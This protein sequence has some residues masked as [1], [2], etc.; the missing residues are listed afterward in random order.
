MSQGN[1][2]S[3][4]SSSLRPCKKQR[5][6]GLNLAQPTITTELKQELLKY[7]NKR[8]F[9]GDSYDELLD[10]Y[11]KYGYPGDDFYNRLKELSNLDAYSVVKS[12][13]QHHKVWGIHDLS[14]SSPAYLAIIDMGLE[15]PFKGETSRTD[16]A[17]KGMLKNIL[18]SIQ[19]KGVDEFYLPQR[20]SDG[21]PRPWS[22]PLILEF[23]M[24][25]FVHDHISWSEDEGCGWYDA[26]IASEKFERRS[27][28]F[29]SSLSEEWSESDILKERRR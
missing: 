29:L 4:S 1:K 22:R 19:G 17:I 11:G 20:K 24:W 3:C 26:Q 14:D 10:S 18:K 12:Y 23:I 7:M 9:N 21:S 6:N 28:Q 8:F 16:D 27:K 13:F 25:C 5:G 15:T 2:R